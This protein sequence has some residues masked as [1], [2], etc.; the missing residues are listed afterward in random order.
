VL[1]YDLPS[2]EHIGTVIALSGLCGAA[3]GLLIGAIIDFVLDVLF[4]ITADFS[5][6]LWKKGTR[7]G[8]FGGGFWY[9]LQWSGLA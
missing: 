4:G 1:T 3:A 7:W 5:D 2:L 6:T 9:F 8:T